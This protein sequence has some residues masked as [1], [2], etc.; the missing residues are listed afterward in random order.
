LLYDAD[1]LGASMRG[2]A[3]VLNEPR[4]NPITVVE[5]RGSSSPVFPEN[6]APR[7]GRKWEDLAANRKAQAWIHLRQCFEQ[8]HRA[9]NGEDY[10][11][12]GIISINPKIPELSRLTAELAQPTM[13][14]NSAGKL[15]VDK[16][17]Q[18]E[19]SPN[20]GD[21]VCMVFAPRHMPLVFSPELLE[22]L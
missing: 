19:R 14:P 18:G 7:T 12:D 6:I 4:E 8:S 20:L 3:E 11:P 2:D 10:D 16:I 17:G 21:A 9:A 15:L 13:S 5:Y 1:G 22:L